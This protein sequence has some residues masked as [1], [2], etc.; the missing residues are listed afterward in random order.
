MELDAGA[1]VARGNP[2]VADPQ[3]RTVSPATDSVT[4]LLTHGKQC[5][6]VLGKR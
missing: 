2:S 1:L 5:G 3:G 6:G 4:L